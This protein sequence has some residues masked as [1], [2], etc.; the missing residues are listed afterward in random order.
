M[1]AKRI[2]ELALAEANSKVTEYP[3]GSNLTKYGAAYGWNGVPW[4]VQ[5]LWYLFMQ[6]LEAL[7]FYGGGKTA[8]CGALLRYYKERG[9]TVNEWDAKPGDILILNFHGTD[10][11]EHC[12]LVTK[13]YASGRYQTVEGNTAPGEEG[14]QDNGGSVAIKTRYAYQIVGVCRPKYTQEPVLNPEPTTKVETESDKMEKPRYKTLQDIPFYLREETQQIVASGALQGRGDASGLD[15]TD[16]MLRA[17]IVMKR[18]VDSK[19]GGIES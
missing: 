5:F 7:A 14:S 15:L 2:I 6:A 1:S 19:T 18:Y 11:T 13:V 16:D 9:Q 10:D 12:G 17:M 8:S 4:C 3:P